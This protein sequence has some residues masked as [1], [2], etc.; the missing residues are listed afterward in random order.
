MTRRL[1]K[2]SFS[3][4]LETDIESG[5]EH[6]EVSIVVFDVLERWLKGNGFRQLS[7]PRYFQRIFR[8]LLEA[9]VLAR[10]TALVLI[11]LIG[12]AKFGVSVAGILMTGVLGILHHAR[13]VPVAS[14]P[15][16]LLSVNPP[17]TGCFALGIIGRN[18]F[19]ILVDWILTGM[20][21]STRK[22]FSTFMFILQLRH[23]EDSI[24]LRANQERIVVGFPAIISRTIIQTVSE[25][26][27]SLGYIKV[28]GQA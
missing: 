9:G 1:G 5:T 13:N 26:P 4:I 21:G 22:I 6:R 27:S 3:F 14:L 11:V 19:A 16:A 17:A 23:V 12:A 25:S 15:N 8:T 28:K 2:S 18:H 24:L 10:Q 20:D 7:F